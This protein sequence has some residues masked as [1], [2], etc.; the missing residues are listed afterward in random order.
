ERLLEHSKGTESK[1]IFRQI[2]NT[3]VN[4]KISHRTMLSE[5]HVYKDNMLISQSSLTV[6]VPLQTTMNMSY[7]ERTSINLENVRKPS[8]IQNAF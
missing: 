7:M 2:P 4:R 1:E 3:I 8:F 6:S 5:N